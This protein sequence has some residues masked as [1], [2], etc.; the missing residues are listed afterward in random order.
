[1][2]AA[3]PS[4]AELKSTAVRT[5]LVIEDDLA[6]RE[7]IQMT[8]EMEGIDVVV[9]ENGEAGLAALSQITNPGVIFHALLMPKMNGFQFMEHL[10]EHPR[11]PAIPIVIISAFSDTDFPVPVVAKLTKPF[12]MADLLAFALKYCQ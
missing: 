11:N 12:S 9:A 8:F 7:T 6:I 5:A 4:N 1:M 10:R 2:I 3:L